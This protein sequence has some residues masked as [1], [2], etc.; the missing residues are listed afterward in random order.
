MGFT[1]FPT[2]TRDEAVE[3]VEVL[4]QL[5][6]RWVFGGLGTFTLTAGAIVAKQPERFGLANVRPRAGDDINVLLDYD[7]TTAATTRDEKVE[8][9]RRVQSLRHPCELGRPFMGGT[10][11]AHSYFYLSR[12]GPATRAQLDDA[13][14][15]D[16][17]AARPALRGRI[18]EDLPGSARSF[19]DAA[20]DGR[21]DAGDGCVLATDDGRL[22]ECSEVV[23]R[24]APYLD[25]RFTRADLIDIGHRVLGINPLHSVGHL[26]A[27]EREGLLRS[28]PIEA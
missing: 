15:A 26:H 6:D 13:L 18:V 27:L 12:Y 28:I 3:S 11:T 20:S 4:E 25:G 7:E 5:R 8:I 19:L 10:D 21:G 22:L 14:K 24:L 17:Q 2:E 16:G 23:A 9:D 1:G